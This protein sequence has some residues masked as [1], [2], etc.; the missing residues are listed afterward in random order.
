ML[1]W[2]SLVLPARGDC[3]VQPIGS[4]VLLW[5]DT[6]K[7]IDVQIFGFRMSLFEEHLGGLH[8]TFKDPG[9][10]ECMQEVRRRTQASWK[11][12]MAEEVQ[13]LPCHLM[14]YP[15]QVCLKTTIRTAL[16]LRI[17]HHLDIQFVTQSIANLVWVYWLAC[18]TLLSKFSPVSLQNLISPQNIISSTLWK[19]YS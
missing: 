6:A 7:S 17:E 9:S 18:E 15:F 2:V 8:E 13:Y 5:H 1:D 4:S 10:K 11:A 19:W 3:T 16:L 12:F 14:P